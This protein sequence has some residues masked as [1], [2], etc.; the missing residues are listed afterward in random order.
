MKFKWMIGIAFL[1]AAV[2]CVSAKSLWTQDSPANRLLTGSSST[3]VGELVTII[4]QEDNRA[5]DTADGKANRKQ[6]YSGVLGNLWNASFMQKVFG[7]QGASNA[8]GLKWDSNNNWSGESGVDRSNTFSSRIA[9]T[10]VRID[11]V[12]NYLVEARKTIRVG[13][14]QKSIILS[15]KVRPRDITLT[16]TIFSYQV[17]D[18]EI[19]Y[20]GDGTISRLSNPSIFQTFLNFLF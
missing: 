7:G 20:L 16:N 12:G 19:S 9:A 15:G 1:A 8:P 13:L 11:E 4:I 10:I 14:E 2:P 17:A 5:N 6:T 18:A 3:K